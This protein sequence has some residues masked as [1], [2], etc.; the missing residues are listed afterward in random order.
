MPNFVLVEKEGENF[1]Y[2]N[3]IP[4]FRGLKFEPDLDYWAKGGF[5]KVSLHKSLGV[6]WLETDLR[7]RNLSNLI[8][9]RVV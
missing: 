9:F 2:R 1:N 5:S 4:V 8:R 6:K 3:T 7:M